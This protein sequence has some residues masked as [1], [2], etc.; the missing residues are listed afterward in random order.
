ME[1]TDLIDSKMDGKPYKA[2]RHIATLRRTLWREHL[3]LLHGQ[4]LDASDDP[5]S[6]P[7]GDI[8]NDIRPGPE[9]KFVE[10]PLSDDL[11]STWTSQATTNTEI[12]RQL[13]RADPDDNIKT[14]ELYNAFMPDKNFWKQGHLMDP[15]IPVEEVKKK[16]DLI[17]GHL[18]WMPFD[19]LCNANMAEPG[20]AVNQITEVSGSFLYFFLHL[21]FDVVDVG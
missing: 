13:F 20:L 10:D 17:R 6:K 19:F 18:V 11:W 9:D 8:P 12:F 16:L 4:S 2:G 14:F 15:F 3:G 21:V 1:D 5:N 7:P